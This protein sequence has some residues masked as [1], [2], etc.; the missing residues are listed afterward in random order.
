MTRLALLQKVIILY[1]HSISNYVMDFV[2][3]QYCLVKCC[4]QLHGKSENRKVTNSANI[5]LVGLGSVHST[6]VVCWTAGQQIEQLILLRTKFYLIS[7]AC[8]QPSIALQCRKWPKTLITLLDL[9]A[10]FIGIIC[11]LFPHSQ[12]DSMASMYIREILFYFCCLANYVLSSD[13][14]I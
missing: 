6:V 5:V 13:I 14:E 3:R 8:P 12:N 1:S 2:D 9:K 11:G 10:V 7:P 4:F